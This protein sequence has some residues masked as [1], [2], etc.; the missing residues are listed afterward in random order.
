[1]Q[2]CYTAELWSVNVEFTANW[3][4]IHTMFKC[5]RSISAASRQHWDLN[6]L[7]T[8]ADNVKPS[9]E[10]DSS[11]ETRQKGSW[12][13][14]DSGWEKSA[15]GISWSK[16]A[17]VAD[18]ITDSH[19]RFSMTLTSLASIP[20]ILLNAGIWIPYLSS[21]RRMLLISS[22]V[23]DHTHMHTHHTQTT[24]SH[25]RPHT[26]TL[27]YTH[28]R[29]HIHVFIRL[30]GSAKLHVTNCH[31]SQLLTTSQHHSP[32][33]ILPRNHTNI[34]RHAHTIP[35]HMAPTR[36]CTLTMERGFSSYFGST[37]LAASTF[38]C[39]DLVVRK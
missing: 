23:I 26:N 30:R 16:S 13:R 6:S 31:T 21:S 9:Q 20:P 34:R 22:S 29:P 27:T 24:Q 39:E 25:S 10:R 17:R 28:S 18:Y 35:T 19:Y 5:L 1:M 15:W 38:I 2:K 36:T 3:K 4:H 14:Q 8:E 37:S 7:N 33:G 11:Y 12:Q 32:T